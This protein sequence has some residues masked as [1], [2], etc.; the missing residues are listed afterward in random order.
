MNLSFKI[1]RRIKERGRRCSSLYIGRKMY[2]L[3]TNIVTV[4]GVAM[5]VF[6]ASMRN[7]KPCAVGKRSDRYI[8]HHTLAVQ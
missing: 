1:S 5:G 6:V 4:Y 8:I 2:E 3:L 7:C